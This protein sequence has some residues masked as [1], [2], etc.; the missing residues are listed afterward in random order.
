MLMANLNFTLSCAQQLLQNLP[1]NDEIK[2]QYNSLSL[3]EQ[4]EMIKKN[5]PIEDLVKE[6]EYSIQIIKYYFQLVIED[7]NKTQSCAEEIEKY[8]N[9]SIEHLAIIVLL[10][11]NSINY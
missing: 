4:S 7:S 5:K 10:Y 1:P 3:S 9:F 8:I 11:R 2:N 6:F